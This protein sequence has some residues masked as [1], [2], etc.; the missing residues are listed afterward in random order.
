MK[1]T[2]LTLAVVLIAAFA[3]N[4][5]SQDLTLSWDGEQLGE[6][7]TVW[8]EPDAMEIVFHAILHN[9][10]D[11]ILDIKV[12]RKRMDMVEG[13]DSQFCWGLCYPP[14][15]DQAVDSIPIA[16]GGQSADE[17]FS[18]HYNPLTKIGISTIE[19]MFYNQ[20]NEDQNVK[21]IVHFWASPESIVE[22]AMSG[23]SVSDV[24]PNPAVNTVNIDYSMP[25]T[26][27]SAKVSIVNLLGSLVKE[28]VV[29]LNANKLSMDISELEGG[30]YFYNLIVNGEIYKTKKLII[31]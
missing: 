16:A 13:S 25:N 12:R 2:L 11:K 26:V 24:Y 3:M 18:A 21:I 22:D 9:N 15:V 14:N 8:G 23:G 28:S 5:Q 7:I 1:K 27:T 20:H 4:A 6:E 19:Y 10:T 17:A 29:E 31:Q 30:I